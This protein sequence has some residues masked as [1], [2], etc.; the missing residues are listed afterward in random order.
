M[1]KADIRTLTEAA[2]RRHHYSRKTLLSYS[3]WAGRFAAWLNRQK[4]LWPEPSETKV[5]SFLAW[6]A[7]RP[8]GCSPATQKQALNA[9]VFAYREALGKPLGQM[10]NWVK[11]AERRRLPVWLSRSEFDAVALNLTGDC[12]A[13]AQTMFGSG[14][15]LNEALKLRIRDIDLNSGWIIVRGGKGDKDRLTC[16]PRALVADFQQRMD[17]L[18]HLWTRDR[19]AGLPGVCLPRDVARKF[20]KYG[21]DWP[22]QWIFPGRKPSTDPETRIIRRHHLHEDTLAKSLK[23]AA[24]AAG[25]NKRITVHTLRH[26]FATAFLEAGE[27]IHQLQELLG[28]K[29]IETTEIYTHCTSAAAARVTSPLDV[30]ASNVVNFPTQHQAPP[31]PSRRAI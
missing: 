5:S 10:P 28:H 6:L 18:R 22:W 7:E 1:K 12:L 3:G 23:R 17:R 25:I 30:P 14:L 20:P 16:L 27:A 11:P 24:R 8:G 9:L 2:C 15:R 19:E 4:D 26:S 29:S 13:L 21:E 31:V